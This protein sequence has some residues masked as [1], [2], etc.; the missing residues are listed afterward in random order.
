M[1]NEDFIV[2][3]IVCVIG[4]F[5]LAYG[6][7]TGKIKEWLKMAVIDAER[8]LGSGTGQIKLRY[9]YD[10]FIQRFPV[11][12]K[13]ISFKLFSKWVDFALEWMRKQI[14]NNNKIKSYIGVE[15]TCIEEQHQQ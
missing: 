8:W 9:V 4:L 1:M 12:S 15:T 14:E 11:V 7:T 13:I 6:F 3:I 10:Q 2:Y 5:T